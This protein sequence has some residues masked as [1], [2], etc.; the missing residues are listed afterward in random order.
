[1]YLN[2]K[3]IIFC[4]QQIVGSPFSIHSDILSYYIN[5]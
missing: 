2:L 5:I 1:M 4:R 3:Q